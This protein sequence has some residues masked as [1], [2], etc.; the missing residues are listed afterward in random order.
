MKANENEMV[1]PITNGHAMVWF[2]RQHQHP[3][4]RNDDW[5]M[6]DKVVDDDVD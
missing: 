3:H 1:L 5:I 4:Q 6:Q 2:Q